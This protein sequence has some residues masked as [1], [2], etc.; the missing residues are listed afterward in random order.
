LLYTKFKLTLYFQIDKAPTK[1]ENCINIKEI[2]CARVHIVT[3]G[4]DIILLIK[5][6]S[7]KKLNDILSWNIRRHKNIS[8]TI[9]MIVV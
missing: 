6:D 4:N 5:S 1:V 9:T 3:G 2:Y 8:N 7:M